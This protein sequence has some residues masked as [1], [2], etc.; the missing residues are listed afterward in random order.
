MKKSVFSVRFS[1]FWPKKRQTAHWG[2][3]NPIIDV[4]PTFFDIFLGHAKCP[5]LPDVKI[6]KFDNHDCKTGKRKKKPKGQIDPFSRGLTPPLQNYQSPFLFVLDTE[7]SN[8]RANISAKLIPC[9]LKTAT[10]FKNC[11][12]NWQLLLHNKI[13][14]ENV[15]TAYW[16][17]K[18]YSQHL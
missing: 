12:K 2:Q 4:F 17:G 6:S 14:R 7:E 13:I 11:S 18:Q 5:V 16:H 9:E 1:R 8:L 3:K 15:L 10:A